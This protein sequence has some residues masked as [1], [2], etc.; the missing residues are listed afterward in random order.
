MSVTAI[1]ER[2]LTPDELI[3]NNM[4]LVGSIAHKINKTTGVEY[5]ELF[6][7][8]SIGLIKAARSFDETKGFK[9]ATYASH[10]ITNEMLAYLRKTRRISS[11]YQS[12]D[13]IPDWWNLVGQRE[14]DTSY[15]EIDFVVFEQMPAK[16]RQLVSLLF[17]GFSQREAAEEMG[18]TP[19]Y[20]SRI[21]TKARAYY[22][23]NSKLN[24]I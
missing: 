24:L 17:R 18:Y 5:L 22:E 3:Q 11:R 4:G 15:L 9:F 1:P 8:G 7:E 6:Q 14:P 16:Q 21:L 20:I 2:Q 19:S 13:A 12:L 23:N 10:C